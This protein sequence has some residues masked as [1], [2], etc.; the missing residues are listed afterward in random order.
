MQQ[1]C[2]LTFDPKPFR[3]FVRELVRSLKHTPKLPLKFRRSISQFFLNLPN[4]WFSFESKATRRTLRIS[5]QPTQ[6]ALDLL[7]AIRALDVEAG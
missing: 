4:K 3:S 7:A 6:R 5:L 2:K 1:T